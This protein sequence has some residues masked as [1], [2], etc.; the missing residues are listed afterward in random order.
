[1]IEKVKVCSSSTLEQALEAVR[2]AYEE[3]KYVELTIKKK[4][5]TR[6]NQQNKA[7]HKY[8]SMLADKLNDGGYDVRK[9]LKADVDLPWSP[10]LIKDLMWRP[11][12]KAMF[13]VDSTAKMKRADYTKVYE[14]LNRH[15]ASK[16][17]VSVQWPSED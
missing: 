8:F 3:S 12:Q 11:L 6:S 13:D 10:D 4:G 15:T 5:L 1:M 16:L 2:K 7:L 9:T 14:V 17:G